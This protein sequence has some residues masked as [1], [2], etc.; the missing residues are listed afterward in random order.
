MLTYFPRNG[1][2]R[3]SVIAFARRLDGSVAIPVLCR[4]PSRCDRDANDCV[5]VLPRGE[6]V[7][8]LTGQRWSGKVRVGELLAKFPVALLTQGG[9]E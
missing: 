7:D 9:N 5:L 2:G 3:D 1:S 8:R 6:L 4:W